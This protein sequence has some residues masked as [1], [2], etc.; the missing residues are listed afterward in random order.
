MEKIENVTEKELREICKKCIE[1]SSGLLEAAE[2]LLPNNNT[3]QYALGLYMYA[4]EE[5]GKAHLVKS[6]FTGPEN[7]YCVPGWIFG[8][9]PV[10]D[11]GKTSH[12]EKLSEGK[13]A[14]GML[15]TFR[16][17]RNRT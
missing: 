17:N 2:L 9:R 5:Y 3:L 6:C 10:P 4:I 1:N 7:V 15:K 13:F 11:S 16:C 14:S 12:V 8:W